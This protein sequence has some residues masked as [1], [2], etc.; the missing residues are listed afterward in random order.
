MNRKMLGWGVA[1]AAYGFFI[2]ASRAIGIVTPPQAMPGSVV[3]PPTLQ[4]VLYGGDPWLAA[5]VE[6]ARVLVTGGPVEGIAP[7][8]FER[9]QLAVALLNPCHED[10]YYVANALLTWGGTVDSALAI[11][12]GAT[13]C[14]FWDEYPPFFLG[15][16]LDFFKGAHRQAKQAL[17]EAADRAS[18]NA[19][20]FRRIGI[21]YE[22]ETYPDLH[23]AQKYLVA[24]RDEA[25]DTRLK[26]LLDQR[27]GRLAG[28]IVLQDAQDAFERRF[29]RLLQAPQEL[30]TSG[31]LKEFPRDPVRLGYVFENG[32]FALKELKIRRPEGVDK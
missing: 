13:D 21:L 30:I 12:R 4:T 24:E 18:N 17:F 23:A 20:V 22:A 26:Q 15:Y 7:D 9:L 3:L 10:N 19:A 29:R 31:M 5:D 6:A 16:N 8:Y 32:R 14:R 27:I 1:L 25:R 2:V 28:L 11:L